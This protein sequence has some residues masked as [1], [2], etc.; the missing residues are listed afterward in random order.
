MPIADLLAPGLRVVFCGTA[1]SAA[2]ERA[3]A[4]YAGPGNKFWPTLHEIGLT[5]RRLEPSE[6]RELLELG[7][8]LT[9]LC[10]TRSGSDAAIGNDGFDVDRLRAQIDRYEPAWLAFNGKRA[11]Q[12]TLGRKR[13][14]FGVQPETYGA[15]R[16]F[17]LPSTSGAASGH[18]DV[19]H[20]RALAGVVLSSGRG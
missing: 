3:G 10:K 6:Y 8:G 12:E 16:I 14:D 15:T 7:I 17:V 4:Y 19:D 18:W 9:D 5:P 13:I 1:L 20:W 11:G 2:S